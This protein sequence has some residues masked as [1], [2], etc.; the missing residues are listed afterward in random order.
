MTSQTLLK[1]SDVNALRSSGASE[2]RTCNFWVRPD[3]RMCIQHLRTAESAFY[4]PHTYSEYH[5]AICLAGAM[6]KTQMGVTHVI[7]PG[8]LMIGNFGVEHASAYMANG[9]LCE[10]VCVGLDRRIL[11]GLL[12]DVDLPLPAGRASPVFLG[13]L[14][15]RVIM[16]CAQDILV[17]LR[18]REPGQSVVLE[19]LA[20]RILV[21]TLRAWPRDSVH[22][23]E[24]D[25]TPRLPRYEFV[26]AYDF[27]RW[28]RKDTFRMDQLCQFL[29]PARSD[30]PACSARRRT[31]ARR[32]FTG[33]C[34]WSEAAAC[35]KNPPVRSRKSAI[36]WGSRQAAILS[37]LSAASSV[38]PRWSIAALVRAWTTISIDLCRQVLDLS[39]Q[40]LDRSD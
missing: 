4:Q 8:E 11:S 7:E 2:E 18:R 39:T 13:K 29:G 34:C 5:I 10:T 33:G 9:K 25:S 1:L 40:I 20:M 21:E 36:S 38:R 15:L 14:S 35:C 31:P 3:G 30:S 19:G 37:P 12:Q 27:M 24:V 17:E 26:R 6:S 28:C 23:C 32:G 22:R 16:S